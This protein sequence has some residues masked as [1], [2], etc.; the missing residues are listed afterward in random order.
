MNSWILW[1]AKHRHE[2]LRSFVVRD[3]LARSLK[4]HAHSKTLAG[5]AQ[6]LKRLWSFLARHTAKKVFLNRHIPRL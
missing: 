5:V 3:R 1:E 6:V 2:E 4:E